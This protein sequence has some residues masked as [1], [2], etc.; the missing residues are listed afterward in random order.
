[1]FY[2]GCLNRKIKPPDASK[3][4]NISVQIFAVIRVIASVTKRGVEIELSLSAFSGKELNK[5]QINI[6][7]YR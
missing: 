5:M 7:I 4:K 1:M 2:V 6:K 3:L